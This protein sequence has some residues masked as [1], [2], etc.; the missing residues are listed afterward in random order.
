VKM[1]TGRYRWFP[2][3]R[4]RRDMIPWQEKVREI[5][6]EKK[7][8]GMYAAQLREAMNT[9]IQG[10]SSDI[11]KIAMRNLYYHWKRNG[12]LKSAHMNLQ[13]HDEIMVEC[14]K[15]VA[16]DVM[17]DIQIFME[18]PVKLCIP[19]IAEPSMGHSWADTK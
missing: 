7:D 6:N 2:Q 8:Q 10:A 1:L 11:L 13:V 14:D 16:K 9:K 17:R 18:T 12:M 3:L 5:K 15:K 4:N 19:M